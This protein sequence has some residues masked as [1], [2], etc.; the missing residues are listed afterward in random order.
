MR[1]EDDGRIGEAAEHRQIW[2]ELVELLD[3][4]VDAVGAEQMSPHR[5]A[6]SLDAGLSELTLGLTPPTLDQV[7]VGS[8]ERSRHPE[9][10]AVLVLGFNERVFPFAGSE[11]VIFS[12]ADREHLASIGIELGATRRQRLFDEKLLAYI[13]MTRPSRDLWISYAAADEQ[14]KSLNPSPFVDAV[15]AAAPGVTPIRIG[16]PAATRETWPIGTADELAAY[17][18]LELR[19]RPPRRADDEHTRAL[20]NGVYETARVDEGLNRCVAAALSSLAYRNQASLDPAAVSALYG[21]A[22]VASV[23]RLETFAACPFR[24]FAAYGLELE[25]RPTFQIGAID[26]GVLHHAILERLVGDLRKEGRLLSD[27]DDAEIVERVD[28]VAREVVPQLADEVALSDARSTY[29]LD[30]SNQE[31][32]EVLKAQRFAARA[33]QCRPIAT[34]LEFGFGDTRA[35]L[36]A[37]EINTS[38]GHK[39]AIRGKIDRVDVAAVG[40]DLVGAVIDY[41]RSRGKRLDLMEVYH[42]LSL[43]LLGYLLALQQRGQSLTGRP[44]EPAAAFYV[45]LV[46]EYRR[47]DHP[48]LADEEKQARYKPHKPRGVFDFALLEVL[49]QGAPFGGWSGVV[50]GFRDK[51]GRPAQLNRSDAVEQGQLVK[52]LDYTRRKIA[53][54]ADEM[55]DGNV[56]VRPYRLRGF[57]PCGWCPYGS[58]CRFEFETGSWRSLEWHDRTDALEMMVS[59]SDKRRD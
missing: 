33:G 44:I 30:R 47:V 7:L 57:M 32:A 24:H 34:E 51:R 38:G 49:D 1:A 3:D 9:L 2:R 27:M 20:W 58:V 8:I 39:L 26:L 5:F 55:L 17:L 56:G 15:L 28:G 36:P 43:Q 18:A 42:G 50:S 16:D 4:M 25:Q 21:R 54:L 53:D 13:A 45:G 12:D 35:S 37:L 14:G 48:S 11:D 10:K 40:A 22:F 41:K 19:R 23:S 46:P 29:I 6:A 52:V 59:S 31:I